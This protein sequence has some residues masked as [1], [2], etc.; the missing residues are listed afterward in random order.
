[1]ALARRGFLVGGLLSSVAF[2]VLPVAAQAGMPPRKASKLTV[3]QIHS[4]HS[5]T[6]T[7]MSW[8]WPGRLLL[9][10]ET[11]APGQVNDEIIAKSTIP[12][13]PLHWRWSNSSGNPDAKRNIDRYELLVIT[14]GGPLTVDDRLFEEGT[15]RNID[16]WTENTWTRGNRGNG[17][18]MMLYS[19]WVQLDA[20]GGNA[21]Q[22][23][24]ALP[25]RERLEVQGRQ[26]ERLQDHANANRPAGMPLIYMIPGHR[27]MMRIYDDI[28][29]GKAPGMTSIDVLF[30]DDIHL[31]AMGNY[32]VT[33]LV[34]AV[35]YQR[36]PKELPDRL[37]EEDRVM[38]SAQA[39]YFKDVAWKVAR[40]YGRAG[41]PG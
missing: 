20:P 35:I 15:L 19:F 6:D 2:S 23:Y 8:P 25:F 33:M 38:S 39:R 17:A 31:N 14:E 10:T 5:L 26:W 3:R 12:G 4:G 11:Q 22:G 37:A 40:S 32:A 1:M 9:A 41:L 36:N 30:E 28:K 27:L 18:E 29:A 24:D 7:Y 34:Y 21:G 13:S 16:Q